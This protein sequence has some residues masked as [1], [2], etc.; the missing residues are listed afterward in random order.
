MEDIFEQIS[1][2]IEKI[3]LQ[4]GLILD[5]KNWEAPVL[6]LTLVGLGLVLYII[7]KIKQAHAKKEDRLDE[8]LN[9]LDD[10][11]SSDKE[12]ISN[13]IS[14]GLGSQ[15]AAS[16]DEPY[17]SGLGK[18]EEKET[19]DEKERDDNLHSIYLEGESVIEKPAEDT[20]GDE[21][22]S[23]DFLKEAAT[24]DDT[25][26]LNSTPGE[27][28][29]EPEKGEIKSP[30]LLELT[31]DDIDEN[32]LKDPPSLDLKEETEAAETNALIESLNSFQ[33]QLETR[34]HDL[35]L[36]LEEKREEQVTQPS[37]DHEQSTHQPTNVQ[38]QSEDEARSRKEYQEL[39]ESF[40]F[41]AKQKKTDS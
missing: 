35:E 31:E 29:S 8:L 28:E 16:G 37:F 12:V 40:I 24:S 4:P 27:P 41:K 25:G 6:V 13:L 36:E 3:W 32:M 39:L 10:Q 2:I 5:P 1:K 30:D 18:P 11:E 23:P 21:F 9:E 26:N 22:E 14:P 34:F 33:E 19:K 38:D 7:Y 15:P 20:Y 17:M